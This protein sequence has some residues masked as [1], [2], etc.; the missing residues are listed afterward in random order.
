[1][2]LNQDLEKIKYSDQVE[3]I[4]NIEFK[5][6]MYLLLDMGFSD[7]SKN[8]AALMKYNGDLTN[9]ATELLS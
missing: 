6:K 9:S 1:V 2:H 7:F 3:Q 4:P 8:Y 5:Q